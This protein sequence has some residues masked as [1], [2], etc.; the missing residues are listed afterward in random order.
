MVV[1]QGFCVALVLVQEMIKVIVCQFN[2]L[3]IIIFPTSDL[4]K[5]QQIMKLLT[6][7]TSTLVPLCILA[8]PLATPLATVRDV[9]LASSS[10]TTRDEEARSVGLAD[11]YEYCDIVNVRTTV[12]CVHSSLLIPISVSMLTQLLVVSPQA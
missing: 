4:S 3:S 12:D 5:S 9:S 10:V 7:I 2:F 6:L 8:T 11:R 1:A